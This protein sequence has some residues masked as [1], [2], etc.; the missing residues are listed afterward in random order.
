MRQYL[1]FVLFLLMAAPV[2]GQSSDDLFNAGELPKPHHGFILTGKGSFDLP[3]ADMAKRFG[4]SYRVGPAVLYKTK[5][6]WVFGAKCDFILGSII[7]QDSLMINIRDKYSAR[8]GQLY[9]FINN[10]GQRIGIP[11]YER[12]YAIGLSGGKIIPLSNKHPDDGLML[13]TSAGFI[14]HKIDIYDKDKSVMQL[15]GNYLKGYD[16]LTNG[17]FVEEYAGY[18]HFA[19]NRLVNYNI[20]LDFLAGFTQGRRDYLYDVMHGDTANRLDIL[21]GIRGGWMIPIFKRK[22]EDLI[23]E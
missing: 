2:F 12:G 20:G 22:S 23:F 19:K 8:S 4:P 14:Q 18:T 11:V 17:G 1:F 15:R 10:N 3:A 13:L 16:R 6:N 21:F 5:S 9:E 7:R